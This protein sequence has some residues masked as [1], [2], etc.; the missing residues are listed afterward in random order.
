MQ[1][2]IK[3]I[4]MSGYDHRS[5]PNHFDSKLKEIETMEVDQ[6]YSLHLYDFRDEEEKEI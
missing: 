2:E 6:Q 5:Y 1:T 4:H 3:K